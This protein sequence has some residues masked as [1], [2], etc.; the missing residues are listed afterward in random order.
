MASLDDQKVAQWASAVKHLAIIE[1]QVPTEQGFTGMREAAEK[2]HKQV[3]QNTKLAA[4]NQEFHDR[5]LTPET[6]VEESVVETMAKAWQ[7]IESLGI[8]LSDEVK[9]TCVEV[10][11]RL[12]AHTLAALKLESLSQENV[13]CV[14]TM[15]ALLELLVKV[16]CTCYM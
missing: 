2:M 10:A 9:L 11:G 5:N 1:K 14:E 7:G 8:E 6:C 12:Q 13:K 16:P 15:V 3:E 4:W